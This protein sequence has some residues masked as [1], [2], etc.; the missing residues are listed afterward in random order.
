MTVPFDLGAEVRRAVENATRELRVVNVLIAGRTGVGKSTLI[1]A[2]F[3][4]NL[5]ETGQ[6]RPVTM[7]TREY[8]KEGIPIRIF[9]TRGLEAAAYSETLEELRKHIA[10]RANDPNPDRHIHIAW[11][12]IAEDSRRVEDAEVQMHEMLARHV[13]VVGVV[14]KSRSDQGFKAVVQDLLPLARNVARVRAIREELDDGHALEPM[15]LASLVELTLTLVPESHRRAFVAAQKASIEAKRDH[16]R[17]IVATA[18][19]TAAGL[20]AVPLPVAD[21]VMIVPVQIG[22]IAGISSTSASTCRSA[23]S[24]RSSRPSSEREPRRLRADGSSPRC[25]S[26]SLESARYLEG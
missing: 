20:A 21:A 10:S 7:S 3:A 6:G 16:A 11:V 17:S 22:M 14:T 24:R 9:D 8:W 13:P 19:V 2:M 15:G 12:C 5:A 18:A 23:P 26:C 25:S 4:G 1:N